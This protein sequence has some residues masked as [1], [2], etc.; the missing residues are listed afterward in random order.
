MCRLRS[1]LFGACGNADTG[2]QV[3]LSFRKK[4]LRAG[5]NQSHV[6]VATHVGL[7]SFPRSGQVFIYHRIIKLIYTEIY[8]YLN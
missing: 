4:R 7:R 6:A 8:Y 1:G 2:M 5:F 3:P